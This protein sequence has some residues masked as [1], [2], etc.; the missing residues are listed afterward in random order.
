MIVTV[1]FLVQMPDF[2]I[3][4]SQSKTEHD[5]GANPFTLIPVAKTIPSI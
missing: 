5:L 2:R 1:L 4:T 3:A